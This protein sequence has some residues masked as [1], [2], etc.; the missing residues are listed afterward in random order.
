MQND[1]QVCAPAQRQTAANASPVRADLST[2]SP[3]T[4][5]TRQEFYALLSFVAPDVLGSPQVGLLR[6]PGMR[7]TK[8]AELQNVVTTSSHVAACLKGGG[9]LAL[10]KGSGGSHDRAVPPCGRAQVF[11]R[12]YGGP[13]ARANEGTA[14]EEE[15]ALGASRGV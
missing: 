6:Q 15:R 14:T 13:I 10:A 12:V 3:P 7:G 1:L 9:A 8:H 11:G 2:P 5:P 4:A